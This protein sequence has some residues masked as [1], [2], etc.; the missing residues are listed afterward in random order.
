MRKIL[1]QEEIDAL[2][3]AAQTRPE[4]RT[5][6]ASQKKVEPCDLRRSSTLTADQVRVVTA[7]H[8]S[9]ARRLANSLGVYLRVAFEMN[10]VSAEQLTYPGISCPRPRD[11]RISRLF[12]SC[13]SMPAPRCRPISPSSFR[14]SIWSWEAPEPTPSTFAKSPRSK[15]KSFE[16]VSLPDRPRSA[17]HLGSRHRSGYPVSISASNSRNCKPSCC[18]TKKFF[19]SASKS[20]C[21]KRAAPSTWLFPP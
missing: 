6:G 5:R 14:S 8:E 7:L 1:N 15:S 9:L 20:A 21:S 11:S 10:L 12:T 16:T 2:F 19:P 3:S 17:K 18:P 13:P 4:R